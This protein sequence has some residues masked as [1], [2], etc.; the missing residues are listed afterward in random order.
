MAG[1]L[2]RA[3][4]RL[5]LPEAA[6]WQTSVDDEVRGS[7]RLTGAW[8]DAASPVTMVIVHGLGGCSDSGYVRAAA[9]AGH[10]R[11]F[12][13]LRLNLRGADLQGEDFYHG[14]LTVDLAAAIASPELALAD[15]IVLMG[16][17]LGGHVALRY[18]TE[19]PDRR[20]V[21]MAAICPPLDLD[22]CCTVIDRP[23]RLPYRLYMLNLLKG[24]YRE[25][26]ARHPVPMPVA[27]VER[28]RLQREFDH[29]VIAP[30]H[31][32]EGVDDYYRRASVG[33]RLR[34]IER[35]AL[36]VWGEQDPMVPA[37]SIRR[38]TDGIGA[39]LDCRWVRGGHLGFPRSLD[40]G[41]QASRGLE[42]QV[43]E[44]LSAHVPHGE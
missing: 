38:F 10:R 1:H 9:E 32:F 26:A 39:P 36:L 15:S 5:E 24:I 27:Q 35:P 33:P 21:A 25:V 23:S 20:V 8:S 2:G 22:A 34:R 14:G 4:R 43:V 28:I 44:W 40:L 30:R 3:A 12:G 19:Q 29:R 6:E 41:Q 31:G 16:Y 17:S 37:A 11:G 18:M 7:V 13:I 42:S